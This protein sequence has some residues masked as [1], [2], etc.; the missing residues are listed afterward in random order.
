MP[1]L[2]VWQTSGNRADWICRCSWTQITH[3]NA[4]QSQFLDDLMSICTR[5]STRLTF[6]WRRQWKMK[7]N[8]PCRV[9][10]MVKRYAITMEESLRK[11]RPKDQV[12]PSRQRRTNAPDTH[13]L[14]NAEDGDKRAQR[15]TSL[16]LLA[17]TA[18][19]KRVFGTFAF[20][21]TNSRNS[22]R[23]QDSVTS[24]SLSAMMVGHYCHLTVT[25]RASRLERNWDANSSHMVYK[26][27]CA[28]V[29]VESKASFRHFEGGVGTKN[30]SLETHACMQH[31]VGSSKTNTREESWSVE[32]LL[33]DSRYR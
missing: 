33:F 28:C 18:S 26:G 32:C 14:W 27:N 20:H 1:L 15:R 4:S 3:W 22:W 10:K 17:K 2:L 13:D 21:S 5:R 9:L 6:F 11:S 12:S 30:G 31:V 8:I 23:K 16:R 24:Q 19:P 25:Q 29:W 7:M